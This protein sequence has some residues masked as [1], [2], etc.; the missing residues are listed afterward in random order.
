MVF[1]GQEIVGIV[2]EGPRDERQSLFLIASFK[3]QTAKLRF[4]LGVFR[5]KFKDFGESRPGVLGLPHLFVKPGK[6]QTRT[7]TSPIKLETL[8]VRFDRVVLLIL[9]C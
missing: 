1:V 4:R 2:S 5:T 8:L 9:S 7:Y 3:G 6:R